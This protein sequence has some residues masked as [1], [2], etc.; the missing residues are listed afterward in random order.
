MLCPTHRLIKLRHQSKPN[1]KCQVNS[2]LWVLKPTATTKLTNSRMGYPK[3]KLN[4]ISTNHLHQNMRA[5]SLAVRILIPNPKR[6]I[7]SRPARSHSDQDKKK[8]KPILRVKKIVK[9][10]RVA[11]VQVVTQL[12]MVQQLM[13][14]APLLT[15]SS[16][17]RMK[18][19]KFRTNTLSKLTISN[20]CSTRQLWLVMASRQCC[21]CGSRTIST[22]SSSLTVCTSIAWQLKRCLK[23]SRNWLKL[24]NSLSVMESGQVSHLKKSNLHLHLRRHNQK[25]IK[26]R[27]KLKRRGIRKRK[28]KTK[29]RKTSRFKY[30]KIMVYH[31]HKNELKRDYIVDRLTTKNLVPMSTNLGRWSR[32]RW[33]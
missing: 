8:Q 18:L 33:G 3:Q 6:K 29:I 32:K 20:C 16:R 14:S 10:D 21:K 5:I 23:T 25:K 4:Q 28:R 17:L 12:R 15:V 19:R 30:N 27:I 7:K 24:Y 26:H 2:G 22:M 9:A 1:N 31:P 13:G 11:Q